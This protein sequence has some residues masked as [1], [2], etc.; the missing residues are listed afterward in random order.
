MRTAT[1]FPHSLQLLQDLL[2]WLP[3]GR[4]FTSE[5]A[6]EAGRRLGLSSTHV[7]KLLS[8]MTSPWAVLLR[9]RRGLYVIR[10][11]FGGRDQVQPIAV[12][13]RAVEP[14]AVAGQTALAHWGLIHQAPMKYET[15]ITPSSL[16][17]TEGVERH[18]SVT[19]WRWE[20][21]EFEYRR[22]REHEMFGIRSVRLDS[23]TEVPM[24]DRE[25]CLLEEILR[26]STS[27]AAMLA[28]HR[29]E[30]DLRLLASY[31]SVLSRTAVAQVESLLGRITIAA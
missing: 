7:L 26:S 15:L 4:V 14:S 27:G 16:R 18:G 31:A 11:P 19:R 2:E 25:R 22:V 10:P 13:V 28:E 30:I 23:E 1:K 3:Y 24:L 29:G 20:G 17:W 9:P 21:H 6:I 8:E 5:E 12:A